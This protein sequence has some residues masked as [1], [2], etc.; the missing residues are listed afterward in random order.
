MAPA[1]SRNNAGE[2][3]F[4]ADFTGVRLER[5]QLP[6]SW[7]SHSI[8]TAIAAAAVAPSAPAHCQPQRV[9]LALRQLSRRRCNRTHKL[10]A[11]IANRS[12]ASVTQNPW[13]HS[14]L[15]PNGSPDSLIGFSTSVRPLYRRHTPCASTPPRRPDRAPA[16]FGCA[17]DGLFCVRRATKINFNLNSFAASRT[18]PLRTE[19]APASSLLCGVPSHPRRTARRS[20]PT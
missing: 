4:L 15:I 20:S 19:F 13:Q 8:S 9:P 3:K 17:Q 16:S 1:L 7:D 6:R 2:L 12:S 14:R 10:Y 5:F 11:A 18:P